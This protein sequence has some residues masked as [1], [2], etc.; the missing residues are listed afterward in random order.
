MIQQ[1]TASD[2]RV[3]D[4]TYADR[5]SGDGRLTSISANGQ[6]WQYE[7]TAISSTSHCQLTRVLRP[8]GLDWE[9][10]DDDSSVDA[11]RYAL[12]QVTHAYGGTVSYAY[13]YV[14]F[15]NRVAMAPWEL[16]YSTVIA[17]KTIEG[18]EINL[19][20]WNCVFRLTL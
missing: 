12:E 9:Y 16:F 7:Y 3:V 19:A 6:T 11:G 18:R 14:D 2:G 10:Y 15:T 20:T 8:D 4:F 5:A 1:I 17:T 13:D